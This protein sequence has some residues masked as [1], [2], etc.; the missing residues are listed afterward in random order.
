MLK[1]ITPKGRLKNAKKAFRNAKSGFLELFFSKN[2]AGGKN[3]V[4]K[5]KIEIASMNHNCQA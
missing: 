5:P 2:K 4:K 3:I 1:P